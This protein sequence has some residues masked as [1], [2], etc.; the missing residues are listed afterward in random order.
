MTELVK[1]YGAKGLAW[2]NM[3]PDGM[4]CSFAKF[5]TDKQ[6]GA[7]IERTGAQAGDIIFFV[8]D[9]SNETVFASLGACALSLPNGLTSLKRNL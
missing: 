2:V 3:K 8:A 6:M 5:M 7:I 1:I 4:Q 9:P